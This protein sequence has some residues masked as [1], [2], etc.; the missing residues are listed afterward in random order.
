MKKTENKLIQEQGSI[1]GISDMC[2]YRV[3]CVDISR[4]SKLLTR[5]YK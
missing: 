1:A 2:C 4:E 5:T 3:V